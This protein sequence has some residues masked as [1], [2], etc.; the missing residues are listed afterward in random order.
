MSVRAV[1]PNGIVVPLLSV[2]N[3]D[4]LWQLDYQLQEPLDAP[5]G[6]RIQATATFDNSIDNV[7]NPD[8]WSDAEGEALIL[9]VVYSL[10]TLP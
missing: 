9:R 2:S 8:P 6:T 7:R 10:M 1:Q 3:W 5:Y 4:P